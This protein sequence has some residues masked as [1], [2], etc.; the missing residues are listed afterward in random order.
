MY[1][2]QYQDIVKQQYSSDIILQFLE[3]H[4]PD[5]TIDY[6]IELLESYIFYVYE[7]K[8]KTLSIRDILQFDVLGF[9]HG[10]KKTA[11]SNSVKSEDIPNSITFCMPSNIIGVAG[12]LNPSMDYAHT[13]YSKNK[14]LLRSE[15]TE[16][17]A[18]IS[19]RYET[20]INK[21]DNDLYKIRIAIQKMIELSEEKVPN[22][23]QINIIIKSRIP[24]IIDEWC[25]NEWDDYISFKYI[26]LERK[27]QAFHNKM[28]TEKD[29]ADA[30]QAAIEILREK[31]RGFIQEK[32]MCMEGAQRS[33]TDAFKCHNLVT[34]PD[35]KKMIPQI[36]LLSSDSGL[37]PDVLANFFILF[38]VHS[39]DPQFD[40]F[41]N[42]GFATIRRGLIG[43]RDMDS[44]KLSYDVD[45]LYENQRGRKL[46]RDG[47]PYKM[48]QKLSVVFNIMPVDYQYI[49]NSIRELDPTKLFS[50]LSYYG[51]IPRYTSTSC[52]SGH[53][54]KD[55]PVYDSEGGSKKKTQK[56]RGYRIRKTK[57]AWI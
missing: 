32:T 40:V 4:G 18:E 19:Q 12:H 22:P 20:R 57:R 55:V 23:S 11:K 43:I 46:N 1:T 31:K 8:K 42:D 28:F 50:A 35:K 41:M 48:F 29:V 5:I 9:G 16:L 7:T 33:G 44:S 10:G 39:G 52:R 53:D 6:L 54:I 47:L 49:S 56:R 25:S 38:S 26:G 13:Q 3:T 30:I 21:Y 2:T 45:A 15:K 34:A 36:Q 27:T 37:F 17:R 51:S 24:G 14:S